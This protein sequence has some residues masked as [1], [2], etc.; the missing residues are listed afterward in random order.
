MRDTRQLLR[1]ALG[2]VA[3][4]PD[5]LERTLRR[6]RQRERRRRGFLLASAMLVLFTA[7][8]AGWWTRS[9]IERR[10]QLLHGPVPATTIPTPTTAPPTTTT[11]PAAARHQPLV[12]KTYR[13]GGRVVMPVTFP[14]GSTA[15]LLYP[16][17]LDLAGM[18]VQPDVSFLR[19][20]DPAP[21]FALM[22]HHGPPGPEYF[23]GDRPERR[24]TT[25]SG[26]QAELWP[27]NPPP[28]EAKFLSPPAY[29]LALRAGSWVVLAP[30][31][32]PEMA[33][34]VADSLDARETSGGFPVIDAH[35]PFAL[36]TES[37]EG[38]GTM[39]S[40]GD[41]A[42]R[43]DLIDPGA[44]FSHVQ[45]YLAPCQQVENPPDP[46]DYALKCLG[47]DGT[48]RRITAHIYGDPAFVKA[49]YDGLEARN[50]RLAR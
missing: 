15:E 48:T 28:P 37:G 33:A 35:G 10:D 44:T 21:R 20:S 8:G 47:G 34:E 29:W 13:A 45:I 1:E 36:S 14:D 39:L 24:F 11:L 5:A 26:G 43:P 3:T 12:P 31:P 17:G 23:R 38:G 16:P 19:K 2:G 41:R 49:V 4:R 25:R 22:F 30:V 32:D 27:A 50:L 7:I 9:Q 46:T 40:I 6:A 18:G 42:A